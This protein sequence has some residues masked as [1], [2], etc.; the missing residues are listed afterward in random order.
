MQ[1]I[2]LIYSSLVPG[3]YDTALPCHTKAAV[4]S[5][6]RCRC[7]GDSRKVVRGELNRYRAH[8]DHTPYILHMR[9]SPTAVFAQLNLGLPSSRTSVILSFVWGSSLANTAVKPPSA[10]V[11]RAHA[12][13][14]R[15]RSLTKHVDR[16]RCSRYK[17]AN[18]YIQLYFHTRKYETVGTRGVLEPPKLPPRH[19]P[20]DPVLTR[21][22]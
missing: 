17:R 15:R 13:D 16:F 5:I 4:E 6:L 18:L 14:L 8:M 12:Q 10:L 20:A 1:Q 2:L 21:N 7:W 11:M 19:T 22:I 9:R 3:H